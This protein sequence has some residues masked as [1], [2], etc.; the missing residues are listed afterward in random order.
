MERSAW[1]MVMAPAVSV[2]PIPA[3]EPREA[4]VALPEASVDWRISYWAALLVKVR[5]GALRPVPIFKLVLM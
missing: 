5:L 2:K 3:P 4:Q 1:A